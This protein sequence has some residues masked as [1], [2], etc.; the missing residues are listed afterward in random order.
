MHKIAYSVF[1]KKFRGDALDPNF[2]L[3]ISGDTQKGSCC[4]MPQTSV[5]P[6]ALAC[7]NVLVVYGHIADM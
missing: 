2:M 4:Q 1:K 7:I 6:L 3:W 5:T